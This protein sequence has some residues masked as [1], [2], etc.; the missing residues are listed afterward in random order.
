MNLN[1]AKLI[2]NLAAEPT[3]KTLPSKA[4]VAIFTVATSH[5]W[6]DFRTKE[7]HQAAEYHIV[8]AFGKLARSS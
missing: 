7:R 1:K 4:A 2:G 6:T 3:A 5:A 8:T